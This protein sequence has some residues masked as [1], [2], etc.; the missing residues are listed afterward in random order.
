MIPLRIRFVMVLLTCIILAGVRVWG[1]TAFS[2]ALNG[3][4]LTGNN[5]DWYDSESRICFYPR[6]EG[7]YGRFF[8]RDL[9]G[10]PQ[11]E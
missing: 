9:Y 3:V 5:E 8:F 1:C 10:F 7:K 11:G 6:E 2:A 4:I